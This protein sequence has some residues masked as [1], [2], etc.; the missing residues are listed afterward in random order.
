MAT[1]KF[2]TEEQMARLLSNPFTHNVTPTSVSFT[3]EFKEFFYKQMTEKSLSTP[4]IM[5]LAGYEP[6]MIGRSRMDKLRIAVRHEAESPDG[7]QNPRRVSHEEQLK[8][9][10]AELEKSKNAEAKLQALQNK[11]EHLEAQIEFLKKTAAIRAKHQK[12]PNG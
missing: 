10:A 2:F 1:K 4:K 3:K 6:D 12:N 8:K 9:E 7:F 5:E 11:V